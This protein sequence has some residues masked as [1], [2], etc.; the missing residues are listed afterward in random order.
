[1]KRLVL[2]DGYNLMFRSYYAT[3]ASGSL[4]QNS[5]GVTTNAIYGMVNAFKA[6]FKMDFSHL[7]VAL[8]AKGKTL[9]HELYPEYKGTRKETPPELLSQIPLMKEYFEAA[10][11]PFFEQKRYEADDIIGYITKHY[12]DQFDEI[13]IISNDHDLMQLLSRNVS[14]IVS[15]RGFNETIK[16]T[17]DIMVEELGISP[18]QIPDYKGL[19]GDPSDNIPGVPGIGDK[20]AIKILKEYQTLENALAHA[21]DFSGK[22]K[23]RLIIYHDQ[24]IFSKQLATIV[25]DFAYAGSLDSTQY[26]GYDPDKLSKFYQKMEFHSF[27]KHLDLPIA[28]TEKTELHFKR[29]EKADEIT[30]ILTSP[31]AIHLELFGTNYHTAQKLGFALVG[32]NGNY[33]IPYELS[34]QSSAFQSWLKNDIKEKFVYDLKQTTVSLAWDG[35]DFKGVVFDLLLAAYL[36][37]PNLTQEDFRV[38]V[39]SFDYQ[40]VQYD[41]E[42]Y[43]KGAK[44]GLPDSCIYERHAIK[45]AMAIWELKDVVREKNKDFGQLDLLEKIEIPLAKVLSRMEVSGIRVDEAKLEEYGVTLAHSIQELTEAIYSLAGEEFNIQSPKQLGT[46]LFEK[47][48]LPYQKKTKSGYSTDITVLNQLLAFHPIIG[49]IID[50]RSLTKLYGTYVEGLKNALTLKNDGKIHT[51]YKQALTQTGRLS[52]IEP[53]LQNIPVRT[54]EGRELRKVFI[55]NPGE[56]LFSCDYSQIELRVLAELA[57]VKE[58]KSGFFND[59]DVHTH[60][61]KLIFH[62]DQVTSLERRQAKAVNFGIIYGKTAWGLAEDLHILPK[63]AE[64]FIQNYYDT[65]PEIK[66]YMESTIRQATKTGYVETL[67]A[68]RRYIPE[69]TSPSYQTREFGKRMTMNAPIQGTA[70]DILK[71]AMVKLDQKLHEA[72]LKTQMLLQ[73]HDELVFS[74]P[75]N[76][77]K[78]AAKLIVEVMEQAV[79]LS[80]P[81]VVD[82]GF[83]ENLLEVKENA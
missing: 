43:G 28:Q 55:S 72:G 38:V 40:D 81:L 29:I 64:R 73:I 9:R 7:L 26:S 70:A 47:L 25:T 83:G 11:I 48:E 50:Y 8:D 56:W 37:N 19:V 74:I 31:M 67:F 3:A 34:Q 59:V 27:L 44:Y 52:S 36:V 1:M 12:Q 78:I 39:S 45:K 5:S 23:E 30:S 80:V 41:E 82:A 32:D 54:E 4:M 77:K 69:L 33:F 49:H 79:K 21:D 57:D 17:P 24:A 75:E 66:N 62:K 51:I 46:I 71:I 63:Q 60:T 18:E 68:R 61:A 13:V 20:T 22:L 65:Y 42:V 76:E 16:Y 6:I 58:L 10:N 14:Q 35:I 15:K 53:N 2:V